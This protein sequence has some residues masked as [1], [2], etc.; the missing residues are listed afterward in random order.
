MQVVLVASSGPVDR[1]SL[2]HGIQTLEALG[3]SVEESLA[4]QKSSIS[5]LSASDDERLAA[6]QAALAQ[7]KITWAARGGYGLTRILPGLNLSDLHSVVIGFSDTGALLLHLWKH[8]HIHS[9]H[10]STVMRIADE[11]AETHA[12]LLQILRGCARNVKYPVVKALNP[13]ATSKIEGTLIACN[14]SVLTA[15]VGTSS[16]PVLNRTILIL[17]EVGEAPYR[18]DRMLTQLHHSS[19]LKDVSAIVLG[20]MT[21]CSENAVDVFVERVTAFGIPLFGSLPV[22]HESPNWPIPVGVK[23]SLELIDDNYQLRI[24]SEI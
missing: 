21:D 18:I 22:G 17:E 14:L 24:L 16:M 15:L 3:F 8:K 7:R 5:Y 4:C 9:I 10:A 11:P 2:D 1:V 20:H 23:A 12:A 19:S 13:F 6:L